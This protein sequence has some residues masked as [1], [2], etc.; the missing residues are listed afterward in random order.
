MSDK[1]VA[2]H[3]SSSDHKYTFIF[4][5]YHQLSHFYVNI[6]PLKYNDDNRGCK[7]TNLLKCSFSITEN[8]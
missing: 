1:V 8:I 6:A 2:N 4:R 7:S 3:T 5:I